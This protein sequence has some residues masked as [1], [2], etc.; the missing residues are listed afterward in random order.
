MGSGLGMLQCCWANDPSSGLTLE[1]HPL[2][3]IRV[4]QAV[5]ARSKPVSVNESYDSRS[6]S[7]LVF[8]PNRQH[9]EDTETVQC[10]A[11]DEIIVSSADYTKLIENEENFLA[12]PVNKSTSWWA[13]DVR[14]RRVV[15]PR[16]SLQ[17]H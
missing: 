14:R 5:H 6:Q 1:C 16:R 15:L 7:F 17:Q 8:Q 9:L 2:H 13:E 11:R 3:E 4:A 10:S 12:E